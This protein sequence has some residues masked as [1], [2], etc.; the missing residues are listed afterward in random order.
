MWLRSCGQSGGEDLLCREEASSHLGCSGDGVVVMERGRLK[1]NALILDET[2]DQ[3][4]NLSSSW[5]D[6]LPGGTKGAVEMDCAGVVGLAAGEGQAVSRVLACCSSF[7]LESSCD[8]LMGPIS[9]AETG[10]LC[11]CDAGEDLHAL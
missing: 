7:C 9:L 1:V 8:S 2:T 3:G 11:C 4:Q 10:V 5:L 6:T